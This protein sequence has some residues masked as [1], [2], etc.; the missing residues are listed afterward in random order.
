MASDYCNRSTELLLCAKL[1]H[2]KVMS[3]RVALRPRKSQP[4]AVAA[5]FSP[6]LLKTQLLPLVHQASTSLTLGQAKMDQLVNLTERFSTSSI[7][8]TLLVVRISTLVQKLQPEVVAISTFLQHVA[9]VSTQVQLELVGHPQVCKHVKALVASQEARLA[10]LSRRLRDFMEANRAIVSDQCETPTAMPPPPKT[11]SSSVFRLSSTTRPSIQAAPFGEKLRDDSNPPTADAQYLL[12][13]QQMVVRQR[14]ATSATS[15]AAIRHTE[16]TIVQLGQIY[17]QFAFLVREQADV[18]MRIDGHVEDAAANVDLAHGSLVEFLQHVSERRAFILK[19]FTVL[20]AIFSLILP[21]ITL[22]GG[23]IVRAFRGLERTIN[24]STEDS[25]Q[26]VANESGGGGE[27][28][29]LPQ[30]RLYRQRAHCNPWSDHCLSYPV[31][32]DLYHWG[33]LFDGKAVPSVSMVDVGCGYGGLLFSLSTLFPNARIVGMEIRLKV[34]D[35]VQSKINAIRQSHPGT[36]LNIA[37]I[38]TNTMKYLPNFF[39]KGQL[40]KMFFLYPDPHFKRHKHKWRII[41]LALLTVYAYVLRPGGRIY[42]MTD[43]PELAQWMEDKLSVHPL[44]RQCHHLCLPVSVETL[45]SL[46]SA[47]VEDATV[48]L[49]ASGVTEEGQKA[50]RDGRGATISVFERISDPPMAKEMGSFRI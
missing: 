14:E 2:Q 45:E 33:E 6:T 23:G 38:R 11:S 46:E 44:F 5:F 24:M 15:A 26:L 34:F 29:K 12:Q 3:G 35:Y 37:C 19:F 18:V 25:T 42:T 7:P 21:L 10:E 30:K 39:K 16:A 49:L 4:G 47:S 13:Q 31:R 28:V 50:A 8:D 17:E 9:S 48:G 22:T 1:L 36:F 32:P 40:E 43:V 20:L 41:S 27:F